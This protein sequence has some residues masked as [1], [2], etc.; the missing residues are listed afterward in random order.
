MSKISEH[1][2]HIITLGN[3]R[4]KNI[5]NKI[6]LYGGTKMELSVEM[7]QMLVVI[8]ENDDKLR[9]SNSLYGH[10][11][12]PEIPDTILKKLINRFDNHLAVNSVVAVYDGSLFNTMSE[13]II[14]TSDGVYFKEIL[15]IP[16]YFRYSDIVSMK[17]MDRVTIE[18]GIQNSLKCRYTYHSP[19]DKRTLM[20]II[21]TL[22]E[23]NKKCEHASH[24]VSGDVKKIDIPK[25][26]KDKS[27]YIIHSASAACG[28][29]GTGLA[30][31]PASDNAVIVPIQIG[32]IVGLGAVFE[33][34]ITETTAKS[35][36]ASAGTTIAGRTISQ[37]LIGWIPGIGN[38]INTVTAAGVT[39]AIGWIAVYHFYDR[40]LEDKTK[41][42]FEGM[43]DGY[44]EASGE[45]EMKF[46]KQA[47]EFSTEMRAVQKE[48]EE[49]ETLINEYEDYCSN[50]RR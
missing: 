34:D 30:Q 35:I 5:L 50:I 15:S 39:E 33:L 16:V 43:K 47:E 38:V 8:K 26:K 11:F 29:V 12:V 3:K 4:K 21:W 49:Y 13:G 14:F 1:T 28:G 48:K 20:Y 24:K 37:F 19:F 27:N 44:T 25:D 6:R 41:G 9:N 31:L 46:K 7:K 40:W 18:I 2:C 42:R 45:Y 32:M 36:I 23:I 17:E 10:H 22:K